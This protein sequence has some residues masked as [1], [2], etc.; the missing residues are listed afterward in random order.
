MEVLY[1]SLRGSGLMSGRYLPAGNCGLL[2]S[3]ATRVD[4]E[5]VEFLERLKE[6]NLYIWRY[7]HA[8]QHIMVDEIMSRL[9]LIRL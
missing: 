5:L 3:M 8:M 4:T 9:I 7:Y 2:T 1:P 6:M